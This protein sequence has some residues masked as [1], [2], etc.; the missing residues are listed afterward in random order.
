ME[1]MIR[2]K[3]LSMQLWIDSFFI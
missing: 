1:T 3:S 2:F